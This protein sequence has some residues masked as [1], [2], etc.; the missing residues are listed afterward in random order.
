MSIRWRFVTAAGLLW[1]IAACA[2][3]GSDS[4]SAV[5]AAAEGVRARAAAV[6][7]WGDHDGWSVVQAPQR[8]RPRVEQGEPTAL[9]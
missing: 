5:G 7:L 3:A 1:I 2:G 4:I 6:G 9:L 8:Q